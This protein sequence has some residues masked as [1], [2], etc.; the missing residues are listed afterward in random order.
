MRRRAF[1][2]AVVLAVGAWGCA[3][4]TPAV[5]IYERYERIGG[6]HVTGEIER[7][8]RVIRESGDPA[9]RSGA[10]LR[11]S[12][13]RSHPDHPAPDYSLALAD[14]D[15]YRSL[16]PLGADDTGIRR[17]R[18][19]LAELERCESRAGER[20]GTAAASEK[21]QQ[22]EPCEDDVRRGTAEAEAAR[23]V[24]VQEARSLRRQSEELAR[25]RDQ[26][27]ERLREQEAAREALSAEN[28]ELRDT[29]DRIK[30]LDLQ[31]ERLR[32]GEPAR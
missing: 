27:A 8:E 15:A 6:G 19:I 9:Q 17:L 12:L 25:E 11:L 21:E 28:Q 24:L 32:A 30:S 16:D 3:P 23:A 14:L 20:A 29:L 4:I 22:G 5:R 2:A 10:H 31:Q 7:W 26:I 13:L 18:A 1:A